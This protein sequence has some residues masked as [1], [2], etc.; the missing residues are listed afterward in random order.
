MP[1]RA[2]VTQSPTSPDPAAVP[3][4]GE[5]PAPLKAT[6]RGPLAAAS[7][8]MAAILFVLAIVLLYYRWVTVTQPNSLVEVQG[9]SALTGAVVTVRGPGLKAPLVTTL[10]PQDGYRPRFFLNRGSYTLTV[11]RDDE[12]VFPP[13]HF[14]LDDHMKGRIVLPTPLSTA[15]TSSPDPSSDD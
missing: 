10:D 4:E 15:P 13:R 11:T 3:P 9:N 1:Q 14:F 8:V 2:T 6:F 7:V 12:P 5:E